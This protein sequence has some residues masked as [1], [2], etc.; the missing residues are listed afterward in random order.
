MN[1]KM[2]VYENK[3]K[4]MFTCFWQED[5]CLLGSLN[6]QERIG[7]LVIKWCASLSC[8]LPLEAESEL[9]I[10]FLTWGG[11]KRAVSPW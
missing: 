8:S 1:T 9:T 6:N 4:Q 3:E 7:L 10:I 2:W 11:G 5:S